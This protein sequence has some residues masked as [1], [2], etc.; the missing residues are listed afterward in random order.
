ML[1]YGKQS[2]TE[3]DIKAV[4]RALRSDWLSGGEEVAA[5]EREFAEAVG[6]KE[7]VAV[8]SGTAALHAAMDAIG[9]KAGDE[10]IVP[11]ITFA[12]T[13]NAVVFQ[14]G[15][16][17]FAD[18]HS[19]TLLLDALD[20]EKK[21]TKKTKAIV[22]VDFA[23]QPCDYE[24]LYVIAERHNIL[25][26]DDACH[27]L[28]AQYHKRPIGSLAALNIFS[29]HPVKPITT[30]EGG[31]V[32]TDN[33]EWAKRMRQFRNHNMN[34][35]AQESPHDWFYAIE[36][37]GYNYR[38]TDFQCALGRSQL[39]RAFDRTKRR[40]KIATLY[41]NFFVSLK[42][43][44]PLEVVKDCQHAYHLYVIRMDLHM[45]S[46]DRNTVFDALR[47]ENIGV[48]LHY[49]PVHLHA[50]YRKKFGTAEGMCPNA[51]EAYRTIMSIPMYDTLA[52]KDIQDVFTA[53]RKIHAFYKV[54]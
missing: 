41:D 16:P 6:A 12:A 24:A 30:G 44:S 53:F 51:E 31:M 15:I 8:S 19:G 36:D 3:Q 14:G 50:L 37:L 4:N 33:E 48:N 27:A 7:A 46:A 49:I 26:I 54:Q 39:Q 40:Q 18:V 23:G 47:A 22:A 29:F 32:T 13:A 35:E 45:F 21:I 5:F 28:G 2:I 38:L 20:V 34:R 11:T 42:G 9:I 1:P 52:D 43:F 10:V 25:V 17:V